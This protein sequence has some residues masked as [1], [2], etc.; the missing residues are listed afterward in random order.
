MSLASKQ[1]TCAVCGKPI[2][3]LSELKLEMI[4]DPKVRYV[5]VCPSES[6]FVHSNTRVSVSDLA[7]VFSLPLNLL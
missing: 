6:I 2:T 5:L 7:R 3:P 4:A 1:K